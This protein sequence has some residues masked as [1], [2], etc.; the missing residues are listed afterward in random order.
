MIANSKRG[1]VFGKDTTQ[2]WQ[3]GQEMEITLTPQ[4]AAQ[5]EYMTYQ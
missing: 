4:V 5:S 1:I 2:T 3:R